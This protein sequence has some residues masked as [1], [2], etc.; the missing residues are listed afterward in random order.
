MRDHRHQQCHRVCI[1]VIVIVVV[2]S[3]GDP[4]DSQ[5]KRTIGFGD[6]SNR[7]RKDPVVCSEGIDN[8]VSYLVEGEYR[9]EVE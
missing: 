7:R 6:P 8:W 2:E 5:I 3:C 9:V 1:G 4:R